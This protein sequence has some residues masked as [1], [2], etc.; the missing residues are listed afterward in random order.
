MSKKKNRKKTFIILSGVVVVAG[1]ATFLALNS[2]GKPKI[3]TQY[4]EVLVER[5][6]LTV[7]VTE[8]G[9]VTVGTITQSLEEL[10]ELEGSSSQSSSSQVQATGNAAAGNAGG[11]M[12][13]GAA[14]SNNTGRST[15]STSSESLEV[16]EVYLAV[17]A[18]AKVGDPLLK[19]TEESV[20]EYRETLEETRD[21]AKLALRKAQL[22]AKST[23]LSAQYT[24]DSNV[25]KGN[26]AQS[27]YDVA[28][29]EL[30]ASVDAAQASVDA[31]ADRISD[32]QKRIKKGEKCS[33]ALAE[34]Q[35]NYNSMAAKLQSA[36]NN[37]ATRAVEARQKYEEAMLKYNNAGSLYQ[38]DT[39]GVDAEIKTAEETLEEAETAL[40]NFRSLIG[41]GIIYAQYA[42]T[43]A[44]VGYVEGDTLSSA[45]AVATYKDETEVTMTV[46]VSQ[47][48]ISAVNVGDGVEIALTA[49]EDKTYEG[50]V[51][52]VDTSASS[53]TSTVSYDVTVVFTGDVSDV[54]QDMT[55]NVTF[56]ASQVQDVCYVSRK[57]IVM[58][59]R[60]TYLK[61]K[62]ED[63]TIEK[64]Q[65]T[66]GIS[67]GINI[68]ISDGVE[69][70]AAV[71]IESQVRPK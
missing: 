51:K 71:V 44:T 42:G 26:V 53:G 16:E 34:E 25:T 17:G 54:Y 48:D 38:I 28:I 66:T 37:Q 11:N 65:V 9:S 15:A 27:E 60:N 40:T 45:T 69:E 21:S 3:E 62:K 67:D 33:A 61:V 57:A 30:Q 58:E 68:E 13:G 23:K 59:D 5:G 31:S 29:A 55:G 22:D 4:K 12:A 35:A 70:G 18:E 7:G 52:A 41:D 46:S 32:Y 10:E 20:T 36:K 49:Y 2:Y 50:K 39:S 6:N 64:V 63:G 47:E 19:L 43:V 24:Y 1:V 14:M 8:S 56:I